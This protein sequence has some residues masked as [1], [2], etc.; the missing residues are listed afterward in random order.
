M[1]EDKKQELLLQKLEQVFVCEELC[2]AMFRRFQRRDP[3]L[4][5]QM[6]SGS[7]SPILR[8]LVFDEGIPRPCRWFQGR[9]REL[10]ELHRLM[11]EKNKVFLWRIPGIGKSELGKM[12]AQNF[13][14]WY[15][16]VLYL[17]SSG[18]LSRD[19]RN[20][21]FADDRPEDSDDDRLKKHSRLLKSMKEDTLLIVDNYN[22]P[23]GQDDFLDTVLDYRCSILF[24]T[25]CRYEDRDGL[26]LGELEPEELLALMHSFVSYP[27]RRD[28]L[29]REIIDTLHRHTFATELAA[30]S[31]GPVSELRHASAG[32]RKARTGLSDYGA[33][34][35]NRPAVEL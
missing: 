12:Y 23:M 6:E 26:E 13:G 11:T 17:N 1:S 34:R 4:R 27:E 28:A 32:A 2:Y 10:E 9:T 5:C 24:I 30:R 33:G 14:K 7:L 29:L 20:L 16:N 22:T 31:A 35:E 19:I 8:D 18:D 3:K 15:T 25:R 21:D